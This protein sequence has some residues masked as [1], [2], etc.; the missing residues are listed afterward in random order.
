MLLDPPALRREGIKPMWGFHK[1]PAWAQRLETMMGKLDDQLSA[2]STALTAI[3]TELD[4]VSTETSSLLQKIT[5]LSAGGPALTVD[6]QT[7]LDS[8]VTQAQGLV[9]K[10]QA[11]DALVPDA[12]TAPPVTP[13]AS[14]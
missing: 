4:K 1:Q 11:V 6:E 5:T 14:A 2:L 10:V 3:G 8:I 13:P 9:T 12:A 7:L